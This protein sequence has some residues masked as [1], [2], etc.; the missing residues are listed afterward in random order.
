MK[1]ALNGQKHTGKLVVRLN[2]LNQAQRVDLMDDFFQQF[3]GKNSLE[4]N[5]K[6]CLTCAFCIDGAVPEHVHSYLKKW[7]NYV[8][9]ISFIPAGSA[10]DTFEVEPGYIKTSRL[11]ESEEIPNILSY[12]FKHYDKKNAIRIEEG[13]LILKIRLFAGLTELDEVLKISDCDMVC[14]EGIDND[15]NFMNESGGNA[16]SEKS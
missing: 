3:D 15:G 9:Y 16:E 2:N 8:A 5:G 4:Y 10:D 6:N 12:F 1:N 13:K 14:Y 11:I 7:D